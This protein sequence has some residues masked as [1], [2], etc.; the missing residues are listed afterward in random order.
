[1]LLSSAN[2]VAKAVS[3]TAS[4]ASPASAQAGRLALQPPRHIKTTANAAS[5]RTAIIAAMQRTKKRSR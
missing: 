3:K 2:A 5:S 4:K 1:V